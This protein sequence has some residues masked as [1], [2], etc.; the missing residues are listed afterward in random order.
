MNIA[1]SSITLS[2]WETLG[3]GVSIELAERRLDASHGTRQVM[4]LLTKSNLL[5]LTE[6]R[7]GLQVQAF[8]HVGKVRLGDLTITVVP[9][10]KGSS[11]LNL[12]R[13]AYGFRRLNLI[14]DS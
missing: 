3:P 10:I 5:K 9:K 12:V 6:L 8:S 11:L 7:H 13:Y 14:S 1:S 2:E 4:E